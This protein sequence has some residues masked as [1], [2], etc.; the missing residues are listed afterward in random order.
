MMACV[1]RLVGSAVGRA[2]LISLAFSLL[3]VDA[4]QTSEPW[5]E[6]V[7]I[8]IQDQS[9]EDALESVVRST[10]RTLE[11]IGP[12]D[13][14][15]ISLELSNVTLQESLKRI[16]HPSSHAISWGNDHLQI[17]ILDGSG[18]PLLVPNESIKVPLERPVSLS[19]GDWEVVPPDGSGELGLTLRAT[20]LH[21]SLYAQAAP[22]DIEV[23]PPLPGETFGITQ[24]E[25]D[26]NAILNPP[27]AVGDLEVVPPGEEGGPVL[28]V[29][30]L[31][32]AS[33]TA[34]PLTP[35][36][37]EVIPPDVP[38]GVGMTLEQLNT[39]L[40]HA[41]GAAAPQLNPLDWIPPD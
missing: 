35:S 22:D 38:G 21:N 14:R 11:V 13:E 9:L 1:S 18:V 30:E 20:E 41:G 24:R 31:E 37:I 8:K 2:G 27:V 4:A 39:H 36:E 32:A 10:G 40:E 16:L 7:A 6:R 23:V 26:S 28:T 17:W 34:A 19:P 5:G 3:P 33:A 25:I 29:D 15:R 12:A